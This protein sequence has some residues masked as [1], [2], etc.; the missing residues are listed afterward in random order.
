MR[1]D[2]Y[3]EER[4]VELAAA[5]DP[6]AVDRARDV[7][8]RAGTSFYWAMRL[9]PID[10]RD[11]MYALYAFCREVD[12]IADEP[13]PEAGKLAG[14][15]GW[16]Q[17]LDRL[18][19]G[20]IP[21]QIVARAL[22]AP[23]ARCGLPREPFDAILRG[24]ETDARG[25]VRAPSMAAL[26]AY[27]DNVA[28]AVGRQSVRIFGCAD[29]RAED[30]AL[31]TGRALQLTNILRDLAE[32][33]ADGRLYLPSEALLAAGIETEDP[34]AALA[35]PGLGKAC[36]TVAAEAA[37]YYAEA[38]RLRHAM[39][40]DDALSLRPAVIMT[41]I[42]RRLFDRLSARGWGSVLEPMRM[43]KIEKLGIALIAYLL[44]R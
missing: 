3:R 2:R 40:R 13:A 9:L 36:A 6:D 10:K 20:Q 19:S 26:I 39:S 23:I 18:Y 44:R 43:G 8:R 32:D 30:F 34:D 21:E 1:R 27:C 37:R 42:Y 17:S 25:P 15:D 11:A 29:A 4:L 22:I 35:H 24:M 14:L 12:D 33:A 16:R 31:A 5:R 41:A 28:G 38:E 7:V